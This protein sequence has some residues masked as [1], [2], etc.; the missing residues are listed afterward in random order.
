MKSLALALPDDPAAVVAA[1]DDPGHAVL[2]LVDRARAWLVEATHVEDVIDVKAKG[3]AIH[4]YAVQAR[5]GKEAEQAAIEIRVRAERRQGQ[6][7]SEDRPVPHRR[8][9][10]STAPTLSDLGITKND[11]ADSQ[12]LGQIP[13]PEF[14]AAITNLKSTG[15]LSRAA[16]LR[17]R[18]DAEDEANRQAIIAA[19][20]R[21]PK[22][23][24][25]EDMAPVRE[26][27]DALAPFAAACRHLAA[28]TAK[29]DPVEFAKRFGDDITWPRVMPAVVAARDWLN[30]FTKE[31]DH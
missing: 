1:A 9:K 20:F 24:T 22:T 11:S 17:Q 30:T 2:V 12:K 4:A 26:R 29:H 21:D 28:T 8:G 3:A 10:G 19:G 15:K 23:V 25:D 6:L 5:L 16:L 27:S 31:M 7:L 14:D 18:R 13:E